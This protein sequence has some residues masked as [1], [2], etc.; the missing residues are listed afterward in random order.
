MS[1]KT[2]IETDITQPLLVMFSSNPLIVGPVKKV[3]GKKLPFIQLKTEEKIDKFI[4]TNKHTDITF[5][6]DT[7][8]SCSE[9][10]INVAKKLQENFT[11][12]KRISTGSNEFA[13]A[14]LRDY[15]GNACD[16]AQTYDD[17]PHFLTQFKEVK[18]FKNE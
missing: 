17:L 6:V 16:V 1:T 15:Y 13:S 10:H 12:S 7:G 5:I 11:N 9:L 18:L 4:E 14:K 3:W 2:S 8:N